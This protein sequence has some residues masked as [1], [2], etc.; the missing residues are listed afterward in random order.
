MKQPL[1]C[2]T[3]AAL[4]LTAGV[5]HGPWTERWRPS[6][7]L[8]QAAARLDNIPREIGDWH[9]EDIDADAEV[10]AQAGARQC[11]SHKDQP[12]GALQPVSK[13]KEGRRHVEPVGYELGREVVAHEGGFQRAG[14]TEEAALSG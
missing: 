7:A 1:P 13:G 5:L 8:Q 4:L 10:F 9:G 11:V 2:I 3:A 14:H 6:G 12:I